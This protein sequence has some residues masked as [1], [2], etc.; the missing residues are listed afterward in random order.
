M[1][2]LPIVSALAL[3]AWRASGDRTLD[4]LRKLVRLYAETRG[5]L[6]Y[7]SH[8][9]IAAVAAV[10]DWEIDHDRYVGF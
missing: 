7:A 6:D 4:R 1:T 2:T 3:E 8:Y 5:E 9:E 10:R